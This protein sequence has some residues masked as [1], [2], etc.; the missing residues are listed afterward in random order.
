MCDPVARGLRSA[1]AAMRAEASTTSRAQAGFTFLE[2]M[3][4]VAIIAALAM[5]AA[6][7]LSQ[8]LANQRVK[9]AARSI[10]DSFQLARAEAIRSGNAHIVYL[11]DQPD[12]GG[13]APGTPAL[14]IDDGP[15][16]T[17][18]CR[19]DAGESRNT[20]AAERGV[21]WGVAQA[22]NPPAP[23]DYLDADPS[24]GATFRDAAGNTVSWVLFRGDGVPLTFDAACSL[25]PIGS[26]GGAVYL[27]NGSRDYAVVLSPLGAVRVHAFEVGA[28]AW[29]D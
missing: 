23:G 11:L 5:L 26:G 22:G 7:D 15:A 18:N 21:S 13:T 3:V 4:V 9:S 1:L 16:A 24:V 17:R 6:P 27:T 14:V 12:P 20:V 8:F 2:V 28:N 25:A 19:I 10:A 29:T